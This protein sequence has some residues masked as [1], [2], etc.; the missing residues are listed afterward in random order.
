MFK[1]NPFTC[2]LDFYHIAHSAV[3]TYKFLGFTTNDL[4][5]DPGIGNMVFN[6]AGE[7][8]EGEAYQLVLNRKD[9][10]GF[11]FGLIASFFWFFT[12]GYDMWISINSRE[13]PEYWMRGVILTQDT[14]IDEEERTLGYIIYWWPFLGSVTYDEETDEYITENIP[15]NDNV[16]I[17]LDF[18]SAILTGGGV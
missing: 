8:T 17:S 2:E 12:G 13:H 7:G 5:G 3:A 1:L 16:I 9:K 15:D 10:N 11:D 4:P 6:T 14:M 18:S